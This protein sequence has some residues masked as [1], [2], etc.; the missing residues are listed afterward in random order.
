MNL[1]WNRRFLQRKHE[2]TE[3][4]LVILRHQLCSTIFHRIYLYDIQYKIRQD[5]FFFAFN[6]KKKKHLQTSSRF[7]YIFKY[8]SIVRRPHA[9]FT[10]IYKINRSNGLQSIIN[11]Q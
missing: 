5:G 2:C 3:Y 9:I 8:V 10:S 7:I 1:C 4:I 6:F 11:I